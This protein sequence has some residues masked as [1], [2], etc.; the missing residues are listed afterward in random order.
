MS[1]GYVFIFLCVAFSC[2]GK[3]LAGD[4]E[5]YATRIECDRAAHLHA[6]KHAIHLGR[7]EIMCVEREK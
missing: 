4:G 7:F 3:P 1:T 5:F 2:Q 6:V